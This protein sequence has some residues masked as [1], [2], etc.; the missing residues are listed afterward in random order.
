MYYS[1]NERD[2]NLSEFRWLYFFVCFGRNRKCWTCLFGQR[3]F[4][5]KFY[6]TNKLITKYTL[7][8]VLWTFKCLEKEGRRGRKKEE[9]PQ[10]EERVRNRDRR[11]QKT[12]REEQGR[13]A[14]GTGGSR[15]L[16]IVGHLWGP[17]MSQAS[18]VNVTQLLPSQELIF[19]VVPQFPAFQQKTES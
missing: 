11:A 12:R 17:A 2:K 19:H 7:C 13:E 1:F 16:P 18:C 6:S 5:I 9:E 3:T 10:K 14:E 4:N 15:F 8:F